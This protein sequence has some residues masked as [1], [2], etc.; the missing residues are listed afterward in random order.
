MF[1][2]AS[3]SYSSFPAYSPTIFRDMRYSNIN[4][5]GL[6]APPYFV[7]FLFALLT[8]WLANQSQQ[9]G[10]MLIFTPIIGGAGYVVLATVRMVGVRYF[11]T[12]LAAAGV[13]A[14][15]S[16]NLAK[17]LNKSSG[18]VLSG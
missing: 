4:A 16:N 18:L 2:A 9:R 17:T 13:F 1:F 10:L 11:S 5:Q 8:T 6:S 7:A 15:I 3:V 12:F 14:T